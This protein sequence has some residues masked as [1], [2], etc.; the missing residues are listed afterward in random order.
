MG[1]ADNKEV[2]RKKKRKKRKENHHL[3]RLTYTH[4]RR[5]KNK[6]GRVFTARLVNNE[7]ETTKNVKGQVRNT[8]LTMK[9]IPCPDENAGPL[10]AI[11]TTRTF[12]FSKV[13]M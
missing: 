13:A 1:G 7:K 6:G 12:P 10:A 4:T 11:M 2:K 8:R 5:R 9:H 3:R